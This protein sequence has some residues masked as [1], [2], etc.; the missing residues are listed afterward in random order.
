MPLSLYGERG[1]FFLAT[2]EY[3]VNINTF[4]TLLFA[5]A[6]TMC[7]FYRSLHKRGTLSWSMHKGMP[8]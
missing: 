4:S 3:T 5:I 6:L 7:I 8:L 1:Y 2:L